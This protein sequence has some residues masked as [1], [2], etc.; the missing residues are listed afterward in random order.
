MII[1]ATLS[2][3]IGCYSG[4]LAFQS[5]ACGFMS[6][7]SY[8]TVIYGFFTDILYYKESFTLVELLA[9]FAILMCTILVSYYKIRQQ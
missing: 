6:L 2:E 8:M 4:T 7:L 1:C 3:S 5:G 9:V